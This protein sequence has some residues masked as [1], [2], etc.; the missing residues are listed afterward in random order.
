MDVAEAE[1]DVT[2]SR[3]QTADISSTLSSSAS[4][5]DVHNPELKSVA[6]AWMKD[7]NDMKRAACLAFFMAQDGAESYDADNAPLYC[8]ICSEGN[9]S[10]GRLVW[11]RDNGTKAMLTH[12]RT[13]HKGMLESYETSLVTGPATKKR[14]TAGMIPELNKYWAEKGCKS[15]HWITRNRRSS[16]RILASL[17]EKDWS[18]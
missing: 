3:S 16:K 12:V 2:Q 1:S 17:S 8:C 14:K 6:D 18:R 4:E 10:R 15:I 7:S 13:F 5:D 9:L 11:K